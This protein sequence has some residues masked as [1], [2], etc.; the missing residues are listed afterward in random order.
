MG[1]D[2]WYACFG[3]RSYGKGNVANFDDAVAPKMEEERRNASD[4]PEYRREI[5]EAVAAVKARGRVT[6]QTVG[7][8]VV[9]LLLHREQQQSA[10]GLPIWQSPRVDHLY[11]SAD[12][13]GTLYHYIPGVPDAAGHV[14]APQIRPVKGPHPPRISE[15]AS[16]L[17]EHGSI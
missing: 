12:E 14:G 4:D 2:R 1:L 5:K 11:Y 15:I 13:S 17:V 10:A 7:A 3:N 9:Y 16:Y 8:S 6:P